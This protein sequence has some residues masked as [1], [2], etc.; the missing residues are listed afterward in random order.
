M[1]AHYTPLSYKNKKIKYKQIL[2]IYIYIYIYIYKQTKKCDK[3][4]STVQF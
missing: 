3:I 2:Y 4:I 1:L